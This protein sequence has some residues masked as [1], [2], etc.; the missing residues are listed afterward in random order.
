M[1]T[2]RNAGRRH[3]ARQWYETDKGAGGL[4]ELRLS[5]PGRKLTLGALFLALAALAAP[6]LAAFGDSWPP[7]RR[8]RGRAAFATSGIPRALTESVRIFGRRKRSPPPP[9]GPTPS[10]IRST[11]TATR[12]S[13]GSS[14]RR[15][16][17]ITTPTSHF[18]RRSTRRRF[19]APGRPTSCRSRVSASASCAARRRPSRSAKRCGCSLTPSATCTS[20]CTRPTRSS[21]PPAPLRF[22]LPDGPTRLAQHRRRQCAR[23]RPAGSLQPPLLLGHPHRQPGDAKRRRDD[24]C[25]EAGDGG[26]GGAE[27]TDTGDPDTWPERWINESLF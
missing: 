2:A 13:S 24:V 27:W 26:A 1:T 18:R 20:R 7:H 9:S 10:R 6:G 8:P 19:P 14:T 23:L 22:V 5:Q 12:R 3:A 25:V 17:P 11:R 15:R 4:H 21:M 16:T